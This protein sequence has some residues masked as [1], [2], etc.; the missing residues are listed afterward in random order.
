M[1]NKFKS[2]IISLKL[3]LLEI[4]FNS[5]ESALNKLINRYDFQNPRNDLNVEVLHRFFGNFLSKQ[6]IKKISEDTNTS[7]DFYFNYLINANLDTDI[8]FLILYRCH[9]FLILNGCYLNASIVRKEIIRHAI[10]FGHELLKARIFNE[11]SLPFKKNKSNKNYYYNINVAY[12]DL[13]LHKISLNDYSFNIRHAITNTKRKLYDKSFYVIGPI[14]KPDLSNISNDTI[15]VFIKP[16]DIEILDQI[17]DN[18]IIVYFNSQHTKNGTLENFQKSSN[19]DNIILFSKLFSIHSDVVFNKNCVLPFGGPMMLQNIIFDLLYYNPISIT[20]SCFNFYCS[21]IFY[22]SSYLIANTSIVTDKI[23]RR[24]TFALHDLESNFLYIKN[25][26]TK[27]LIQVDSENTR[28]VLDLS[29]KEYLE[30]L[31]KFH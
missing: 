19:S 16:P 24:K 5:H 27:K 21:E 22:N 18:I 1:K 31:E 23:S 13:L 25:L 29:V 20:I 3:F 15:F 4:Y 8:K 11:L 14:G 30:H 6:I 2:L 9:L 17:K 28:Y 26:Y 12:N 10:I 7:F